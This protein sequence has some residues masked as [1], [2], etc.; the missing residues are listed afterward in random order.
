M[1]TLGNKVSYYTLEIAYENMHRIT[2]KQQENVRDASNVCENTY[3][4]LFKY[5]DVNHQNAV[6]SIENQTNSEVEEFNYD[7][8]DDRTIPD[9]LVRMKHDSASSERTAKAACTKPLEKDKTNSKLLK[10]QTPE[11]TNTTF[12]MLMAKEH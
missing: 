10:Y 7:A 4:N 6:T 8:N 9:V 5:E 12:M 2:T 1:N 3:D 11:A